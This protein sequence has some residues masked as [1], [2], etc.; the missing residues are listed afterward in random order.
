MLILFLSIILFNYY[1]YILKYSKIFKTTTTNTTTT[2][3]TATITTTITATITTTITY[4][5]S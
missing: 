4:L 1:I 5:G 2:T 3:I